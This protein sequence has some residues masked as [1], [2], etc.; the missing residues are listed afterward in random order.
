MPVMAKNGNGKKVPFSCEREAYQS[1]FSPFSTRADHVHN[2]WPRYSKMNKC[3]V[4]LELLGPF[5]IV[6][7]KPS[8]P[9]QKREDKQ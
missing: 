4:Q 3:A 6:E 8:A 7:S 1:H 5:Q 9:N 2:T